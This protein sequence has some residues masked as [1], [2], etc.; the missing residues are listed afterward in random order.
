MHD[1]NTSPPRLLAIDLDG[2]LL[3]RD[4]SIAQVDRDAVAECLSRGIHV[5]ICTGRMT[6]GALGSAQELGLRTPMICADGGVL[7]DPV[8]GARLHQHPMHLPTATEMVSVLEGDGFQTCVFLY[9]EIYGNTRFEELRH[10]LQTWSPK[11]HLF[12]RLSD[13]STWKNSTDI[14]VVLAVGP[15]SSAMAHGEQ[16]RNTYAAHADVVTWRAGGPDSTRYAVM[17]RPA[18]INKGS[19]LLQLAGQLGVEQ[20]NIAAVGDWLNDLPMLAVAGRSFAMGQSPEPVREQATDTLVA[21]CDTGG[22]VAE[23]VDRWLGA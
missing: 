10:F 3:R 9:N 4:K 14:S 16:L 19:A 22:G 5:A 18:G 6:L 21:T 1:M 11:V 12:D 15:K 2:T 13:V 17:A 23:A 8:T 20:R 7:A